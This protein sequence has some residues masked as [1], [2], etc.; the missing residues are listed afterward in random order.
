MHLPVK[1]MQ[2]IHINCWLSYIIKYKNNIS[3]D[4]YICVP[5]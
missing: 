5:Q 2:Y 1:Q 3:G 4:I